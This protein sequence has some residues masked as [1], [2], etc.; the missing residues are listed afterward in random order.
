MPGLVMSSKRA[1]S[2]KL[3]K[4]LI[5]AGFKPQVFGFKATTL[6]KKV[7][8]VF[9]REIFYSNGILKYAIYVRHSL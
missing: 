7:F 4:T 6:S 2:C 3:L 5:R 8:E 1:R 9:N